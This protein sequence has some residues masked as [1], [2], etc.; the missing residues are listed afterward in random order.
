MNLDKS[1]SLKRL[2]SNFSYFYHF[3]PSA[4]S[5]QSKN[6]GGDVNCSWMTENL[7]GKV[8]GGSLTP[9]GG[10]GQDLCY[11]LVPSQV[12]YAPYQSVLCYRVRGDWGGNTCNSSKR[13]TTAVSSQLCSRK[14]RAGPLVTQAGPNSTHLLCVCAQS[15]QSC[16]TLCNP[17]D[18]NPAGSSVH[19]I[20]QARILEWVA[21]SG[22]KQTDL[23]TGWNS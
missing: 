18:C 1:R 14:G 15:F 21:L 10:L 8:H 13:E 17:M 7:P 2:A 3:Y 19:G 9:Q 11:K 4:L 20:L 12:F 16:L 6:G 22:N 23:I 5:F